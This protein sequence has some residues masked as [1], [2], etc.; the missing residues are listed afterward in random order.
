MNGVVVN[1][2]DQLAPSFVSALAVASTSSFTVSA[3]SAVDRPPVDDAS[4]V[5]DTTCT[6]VLPS[7]S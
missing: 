1:T 3:S 4:R 5:P 2:H 6:G 7:Q